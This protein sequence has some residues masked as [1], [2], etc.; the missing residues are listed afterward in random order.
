VSDLHYQDEFDIDTF[1]NLGSPDAVHS[2]DT[3]SPTEYLSGPDAYPSP[4]LSQPNPFPSQSLQYTPPLYNSGQGSPTFSYGFPDGFPTMGRNGHDMSSMRPTHHRTSS[5][6]LYPPTISRDGRSHSRGPGGHRSTISEG[7]SGFL[8][9]DLSPE[10]SMY[11]GDDLRGR[12]LARARSAPSSK[13]VFRGKSPYDRPTSQ[14][15]IT[16][17]EIPSFNGTLSGQSTPE[18]ESPSP[19]SAKGVVATDAMV[20]ASL[21]RRKREANFFCI[22]CGASFTTENSKKRTF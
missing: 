7:S 17:L 8:S 9:P 13:P 4:S 16:R 15:E 3:T 20:Q 1:L 19:S 21:K 2:P 6:F 14:T 18:P 5:D 10:A 22:Q 12:G 11:L